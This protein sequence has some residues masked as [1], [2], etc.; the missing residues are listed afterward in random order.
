MHCNMKLSS[1]ELELLKSSSLNFQNAKVIGELI[2]SDRTVGGIFMNAGNGDFS[3]PDVDKF[4]AKYCAWWPL[5][6]ILLTIAK[7]FTGE[8]TDKVIDELLKLGDR[9]CK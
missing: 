4:E 9:V 5:A 2:N 3:N 6:R 7:V 1:S 8:K